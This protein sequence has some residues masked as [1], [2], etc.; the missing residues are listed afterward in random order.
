MTKRGLASSCWTNLVWAASSSGVRVCATTCWVAKERKRAAT[1]RRDLAQRICALCL[2]VEDRR[3]EWLDRPD[4]RY[5]HFYVSRL[6][7]NGFIEAS[8]F[9]RILN[10]DHGDAVDDPQ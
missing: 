6:T 8:F 2:I 3:S 7:V 1:N 9:M 10:P 4:C 5:V